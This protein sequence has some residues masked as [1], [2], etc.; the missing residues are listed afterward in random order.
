MDTLTM[1]SVSNANTALLSLT[2]HWRQHSGRHLQAADEAG[3]GAQ[4]PG[5]G[6]AAARVGARRDRVQA[7][8]ARPCSIDSIHHGT[9]GQ[10]SVCALLLQ[11][12]AANI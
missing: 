10:S 3:H 1:A 11:T 12:P 7:P 6:A 8:I 4:H 9:P 5:V 2:S